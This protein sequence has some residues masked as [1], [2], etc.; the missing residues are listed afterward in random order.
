YVHITATEISKIASFL[1]LTE[2]EFMNKYVRITQDR[3]GLSL[4]E[5]PDGSCVF[6]KGND[7]II[8]DVKPQQCL[9]FP[10]KWNF[11]GFREVCN[12]KERTPRGRSTS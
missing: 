1:N 10:N 12:V 5:N 8:N 2:D 3:K 11:E 7:C 9:D 4:I 6:L